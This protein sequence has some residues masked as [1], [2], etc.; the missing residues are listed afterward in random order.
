MKEAEPVQLR[1][2][3][4]NIALNEAERIELGCTLNS[5]TSTAKPAFFR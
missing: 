1:M 4:G 5:L 3:I 2:E